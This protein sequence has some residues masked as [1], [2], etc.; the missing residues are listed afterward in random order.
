MDGRLSHPSSYLISGASGCGKTQWTRKLLE[1]WGVLIKAGFPDRI[2]W[3]YAEYQPAYSELLASFPQIEFIQG[4]PED[5]CDMFDAQTCNLCIIDDLMNEVSGNKNVC[6][7]FTKTSHHRNLSVI[8]ITQNLFFQG[9]ESRTISLNAHYIVLFKNPRDR[10]QIVNL[11]KQMFPGNV[12]FMREAYEDAT[13]EAYGYLLIDLKPGT[14]DE[15]RL[16]TNIFP[17]QQPT[18]VY[19][20][21]SNTKK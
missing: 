16:R 3:F 14:P 8:F 1:S 12:R 4:V 18:T 17:D 7:L 2:V 19:V 6:N 5:V 21:R 20:P 15:L 9:R 10:S 13:K 11:A